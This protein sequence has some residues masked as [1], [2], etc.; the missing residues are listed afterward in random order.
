MRQS[1]AGEQRQLLA[2]HQAVHQIDGRHPGLDEIARQGAH[3]RVDRESIDAHPANR[4]HRRACVG[5]LT[6]AVEGSAQHAGADAEQQRLVPDADA[7]V[8]HSQTHG[9]FEHLD[10]EGTLIDCSDASD[11]LAAIV[12]EHIDARVEADL[13]LALEKQQRPLDALNAVL[14][15]EL[16]AHRPAPAASRKTPS[17]AASTGRGYPRSDPRRSPRRCAAGCAEWKERRCHPG[18]R[19]TRR[20]RVP[21]R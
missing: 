19:R 12:V 9:G 21:G 15:R 8:A 2:A 1:R 18:A 7:R 14:E 17:R 11:P 3:R 5:R 16:S 4:R 6:D 20:R 10:D 13:D